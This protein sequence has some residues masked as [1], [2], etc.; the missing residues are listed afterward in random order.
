MARTYVPQNGAIIHRLTQNFEHVLFRSPF[1]RPV[2]VVPVAQQAEPPIAQP[3]TN[4]TPNAKV[5]V[6]VLGG[7]L[8]TFIVPMVALHWKS[9]TGQDSTPASIGAAV[10][11]IL[12]FVIQ[13]WV[14][15]R[16]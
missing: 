3:P 4:W 10:T 1:R 16:K 2:L 11:S 5:S 6:G 15:E 8:A 14:P 7:A 9:W 12:T 13:Y